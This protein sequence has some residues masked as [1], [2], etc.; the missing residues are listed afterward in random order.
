MTTAYTAYTALSRHRTVKT[1][2]AKPKK[3]TITKP[4]PKSTLIF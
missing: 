4:K 2:N 1:Q 3:R